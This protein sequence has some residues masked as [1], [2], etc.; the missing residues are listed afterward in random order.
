MT[1]NA[2]IVMQFLAI[3]LPAYSEKHFPPFQKDRGNFNFNTTLMAVQVQFEEE[4][5]SMVANCSHYWLKHAK[6]CKFCDN[7]S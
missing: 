6:I 7:C 5:K 4:V 3:Q 1:T 2:Q